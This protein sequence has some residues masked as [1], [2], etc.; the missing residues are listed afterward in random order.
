[1]IEYQDYSQHG[2][3]IERPRPKAFEFYDRYDRQEISELIALREVIEADALRIGITL[4]RV[5]DK[6]GAALLLPGKA[7]TTELRQEPIMLNMWR[8]VCRKARSPELE[9]MLREL[10]EHAKRHASMSHER[11]FVFDEKWEQKIQVAYQLAMEEADT[12]GMD[13]IINPD[14]TEGRRILWFLADSCGIDQPRKD[15]NGKWV[16]SVAAEYSPNLSD[17]AMYQQL[18]F[19]EMIAS[20]NI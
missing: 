10:R 14:P 12:C 16:F 20:S 2:R 9:R 13:I 19:P 7:E 15:E 18:L 3:E 5:Y 11:G 6:N 4:C 17:F 8:G 1:M